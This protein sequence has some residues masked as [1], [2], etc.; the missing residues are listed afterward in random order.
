MATLRLENV[1]K[2]FG[3]VTALRDVSLEIRDGEFLA[4]LGPPEDHVAADD[5]R[6]RAA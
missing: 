3:N 2:R 5:C 4:V 6:P 1:T